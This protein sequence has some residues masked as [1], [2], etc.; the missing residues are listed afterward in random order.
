MLTLVLVEGQSWDIL[1]R[2]QP[3]ERAASAVGPTTLGHR[4]LG[5]SPASVLCPLRRCHNVPGPD[6]SHYLE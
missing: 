2:P 6:E 3:R 1:A 4:E 5:S